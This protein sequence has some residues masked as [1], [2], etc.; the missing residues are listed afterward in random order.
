MT[1]EEIIQSRQS[2][3]GSFAE[4]SRLTQAFLKVAMTGKNWNEL[5]DMQHEALHMTLHKISRLL[6]GDHNESDHWLDGG[7]YMHLPEKFKSS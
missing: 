7:N 1:G 2:T 6:S 4:N 5:N 3:H